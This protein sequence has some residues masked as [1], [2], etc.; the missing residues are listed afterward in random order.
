MLRTS[1]NI[2]GDVQRVNSPFRIGPPNMVHPPPSLIPRDGVYK[3]GGVTRK[4]LMKF[5][6]CPPASAAEKSLINLE[7]FAL[8]SF[9]V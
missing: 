9:S 4:N 8:P 7:A 6:K 2:G 5:R 1:R 3:K